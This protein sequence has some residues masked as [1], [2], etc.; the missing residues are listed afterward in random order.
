MDLLASPLIK[1]VGWCSSRTKHC[2]FGVCLNHPLQRRHM[3][4]R[5]VFV[6]FVTQTA[7]VV[8]PGCLAAGAFHKSA[9]EKQLVL[10]W[11]HV[12][13]FMFGV[14]RFPRFDRWWGIKRIIPYFFFFNNSVNI[15]IVFGQSNCWDLGTKA[16]SLKIG[17]TGQQA[18][19]VRQ[20]A[21]SSEKRVNVFLLPQWS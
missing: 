3:K 16:T 17:P 18:R 6:F 13:W 9:E 1:P 20:W 21:R 10:R 5:V 8:I 11:L 14:K 7:A 12:L 4:V 15:F 19:V 2:Q